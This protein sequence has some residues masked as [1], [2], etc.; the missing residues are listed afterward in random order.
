MPRLAVSATLQTE[1]ISMNDSYTPSPANIPEMEKTALRWLLRKELPGWSA[2]HQSELD[3]WV[4]ASQNHRVSYVKAKGAW[5]ILYQAHC[6]ERPEGQRPSRADLA[7]EIL[8]G[9]KGNS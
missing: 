8:K 5:E 9:L 6:D 1:T 3:Q 4:Q 7:Q 2:T